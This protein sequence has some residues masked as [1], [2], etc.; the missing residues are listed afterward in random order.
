MP[1]A[2]RF[3]SLLNMAHKK[4][5]LEGTK[6]EVR[7]S[8]YLRKVALLKLASLPAFAAIAA[9]LQKLHGV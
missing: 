2:S 1:G 5:R 8:L 3:G 6:V 9:L 7:I 4:S